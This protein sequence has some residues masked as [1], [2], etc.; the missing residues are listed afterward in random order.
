VLTAALE[1]GQG[2][3]IL[4][5]V[6]KQNRKRKEKKHYYRVRGSNEDHVGDKC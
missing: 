5:I 3:G 2:H 1:V 4:V 6:S